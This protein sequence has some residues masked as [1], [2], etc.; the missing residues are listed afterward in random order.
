MADKADF[1]SRFF[2]MFF[3][4]KFFLFIHNFDCQTGRCRRDLN[5]RITVLPACHRL[6][7]GLDLNPRITVLQ[8]VALYR[9]ATRPQATAGRQT[10]ALDRLAT[11]PASLPDYFVPL[12][13]SRFPEI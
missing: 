13:S 12:K 3:A 4:G 11:T 10:V 6:R 5:P 2:G 7:S 9:L 1:F 8:T